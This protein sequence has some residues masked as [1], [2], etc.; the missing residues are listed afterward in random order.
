MAFDNS[1]SPNGTRWE[2]QQSIDNQWL[3]VDLGSVSTIHS[4]LLNWESAKAATYNLQWSNDNQTWTNIIPEVTGNTSGGDSTQTFTDLNQ[5]ARYVRMFELTRA[6]NYGTSLFEFQV[7]GIPGSH[8]TNTVPSVTGDLT[9]SGAVG[10]TLPSFTI[11]ATNSPTNFT[12]NGLPPG[13][14]INST[15]VISGTPTSGGVFN[16]TVTAINASGS[17]APTLVVFTISGG[18]ALPV[19]SATP[20]PPAGTANTAYTSYQFSATNGPITSYQVSSGALPTGLSLSTAGVLSGTP[21]TAGSYTFGVTATSAS[22]TGS[23]QSFTIT[24][25]AAGSTA[26]VVSATPAPTTGTVG[27]AYTSYQ[28]SATNGPITSFQVSSGALPTSLSLSTAGVLSG[29]PSATGTFTFGVTATNSSGTGTATSFTITINAASGGSTPVVSG[30]PL[31]GTLNNAYANY[32]FSATNGPITSYQV[33]SG[34]LPTGLSLSSAGALTG[35]PSATGTYT[36][37]VTATSAAGTGTATSFTIVIGATGTSVIST[38]TPGAGLKNAFYTYILA[39]S[40]NPTSYT[41]ASGTLPPGLS[42]DSGLSRIDGTP[43]TA[44]TYPFTLAAV[45]STGTGPVVSMTITIASN[46]DSNLALAGTATSS[47]PSTDLG[48]ASHAIDGNQGTRWESEQG[49]AADPSS[50]TVDLGASYIVSGIDINWE[51]ASAQNY[52]IQ[53]SPTGVAG[54]WTT[55]ATVTNN[56]GGGGVNLFA[57]LNTAARFVQ[58]TGTS[59]NTPYGYSIWEFQVFG[60]SAPVVSAT[61]APTV[62]MVGTAY[63]SYQFRATN[64]PISTYQVLSGTLPTGLSLSPA[65]A[66]A[67]TPTA[68]GTYN[69]AISATS[70]SGSTGGG[71]S[72]TITINPAPAPVV[73]ASPGP[74]DGTVSNGYNNYQFNATNGPI[75]SYQVS[76]GT[77]PTG[78]SLSTAGALTGTPT[79]AGTYTFGVTAT[80]SAAGT[81]AATSFTIVIGA[82]NT[83][84]IT[85]VAPTAGLQ[86]A[87]Y[88]Y[89]I[90]ASNNPSGYSVTSGSMPPG[91]SYDSGLSRIDGTPTS[92]GTYAFSLAAANANG[93]GPAVS[94]TI[95]IAANS[96]NN[97]ALAGTATSS[98]PS[99]DMASASQA[100]DG[101]QGTRWESQHG[102]AADPSSITV[103]LGQV[104]AISGI[105]INWENASA[106]N[107]TIQVSS[108]GVAGSW[109]PLETVTN[110]PGGGG[111]NLFSGLNTTARFVQMNGTAR[112]T[113]YGYSIWE[114]QI[115]GHST[116]TNPVVSATPAPTVGT[117]GTVYNGYQFSATN[118]PISSYQVV[119]GSLPTGLSLS[120]VGVLS[121]TPTV[122]GSYMFGVTA[123]NSSNATGAATSF[124][125]TIGSNSTPVVNATPQALDGTVGGGYTNYQFSATNGPISIYQVSSGTLP[126]GLTLSSAG[127]LSGTPNAA[128]TYT[129]GVTATNSSN[130]TSA[131]TS[132]TVVVGATGTSVISTV[133]P[134]A[135]LQNAYYT[136]ILAASANPT[137]YTVTSGSLPP[138]MSYDSGLGRLDGTPTAAGTYTFTLAA[139]NASGT[140]PAATLTITIAANSDSN[141]ALAGTATSSS[142][143]TDI[144]AASLAI[145]NN[146]GTRWESEHGTA[147]DPSSITIDLGAVHT[148]SAVGIDWENASAQNY[149]IQ[150]NSTGAAGSWTTVKTVTNN[151]GGGGVNLFSG[152][153]ATGRYVQMM[154]TSRNTVYGYSIWEFQVFAH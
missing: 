76:S 55:L 48:A 115:F 99:T 83:P 4:I 118:G 105:D 152:L 125:I 84:V 49:T 144:S 129:F 91:L 75:T 58:M 148:I 6:S 126:T 60:H 87:F 53:V 136:Y 41:V 106:Q 24:I 109:T 3:E 114:F 108:T 151:P 46:S 12:A 30:T 131:A 121:G 10:T 127:V 80:S 52:T 153:S 116:S 146:L 81:G 128:G 37:G 122:A 19:V 61:P 70:T 124:T 145:D 68:P 67:G 138:G 17:S 66:L 95:T 25:A 104:Y 64:G 139:V 1:F 137:S 94:M 103:D 107:Y 34:A 77:L 14:G 100:I 15:G 69:F 73:N 89:I 22:G 21:S 35:T 150:V 85:T 27:T 96:D 65:G 38:V 33:S 44:G 112:T 50:I 54:S 154:G 90:A 28:F 23:A 9:D 29:T 92:S 59:R 133:T 123:T 71:T 88:T 134:V 13:L 36:F 147:A 18:T 101:N 57:G 74:L 63:T 132:F 102:T 2:S 113:V 51:N 5:Q 62:G 82:T 39:G 40:A 111:V 56:P 97:L 45:N 135:G 32:Q 93:T 72:F 110:N 42:Y 8:A 130:L 7:N 143:G 142:P 141:L 117:V 86:S 20:A 140:G 149:T 98:S 79:T 16:A 43:T 78:L 119:S 26:P 120:P 11:T 47:S 31:D